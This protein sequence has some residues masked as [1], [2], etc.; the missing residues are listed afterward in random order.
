[1]HPEIMHR[2]LNPEAI[3]R[4]PIGIINVP[5]PPE[6]AGLIGEG[7]WERADFSHETENEI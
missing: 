4:F 1:M 2:S 6:G 7:D 3:L 5:H